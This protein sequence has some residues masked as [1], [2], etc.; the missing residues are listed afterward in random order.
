MQAGRRR[1]EEAVEHAGSHSEMVRSPDPMANRAAC[2][3]LPWVAVVNEDGEVL[4]NRNVPNGMKPVLS[5]IGGLPGTPT[6]YRSAQGRGWP[7]WP[8]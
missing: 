6:P 8:D 1:Y 5:V 2:R 3:P 4:A 7:D